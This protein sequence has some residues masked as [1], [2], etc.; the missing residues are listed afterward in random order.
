MNCEQEFKPID[1]LLDS[2]AETRAI[3]SFI[4]SLIKA[5]RQMRRIFTYL[6]YQYPCF[7]FN[8][9]NPLINILAENL[10]VYFE[11]FINGFN[12]IYPKTVE[13]I[14]GINYQSSFD[15]LM[16]AKRYRNK[17]FHGQLTGKKLSRKGLELIIIDI[18]SWCS[19]LADKMNSEIGYDGFGRNSFRKSQ[20]EI[21][22][23]FI[24]KKINNRDDYKKFIK[25][26]MER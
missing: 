7:K 13:E 1:V 6:V 9:I 25:K 8:D 22:Q 24:I 15:K 2:D 23:R 11:G 12:K 20:Y 18:R 4:L 17:I 3:D 10:N 5:E 19:N 21:N 14:F 26:Y 16:D